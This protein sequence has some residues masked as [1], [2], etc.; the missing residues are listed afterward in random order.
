MKMEEQKYRRQLIRVVATE[1]PGTQYWVARADVRYQDRK[2]FFP[3]EG[4]RDKFTTKEAAE[5]NIIEEAKK[6]IDSHTKS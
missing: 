4:P 3:L 5:R 6:L 1:A 2:G